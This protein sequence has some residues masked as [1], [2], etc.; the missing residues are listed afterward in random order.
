MQ[1]ATENFIA[2]GEEIAN[3]N[4]DVKADMMAAVDEVRKTGLYDLK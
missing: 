2:S 4:P 1:R 3:E